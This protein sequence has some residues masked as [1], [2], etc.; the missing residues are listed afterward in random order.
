LV[1]LMSEFIGKVA[2][3]AEQLNLFYHEYQWKSEAI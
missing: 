2:K 1:F 3:L